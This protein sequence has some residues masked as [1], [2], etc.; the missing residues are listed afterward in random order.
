M[1]LMMTLV[2][3]SSCVHVPGADISGMYHHAQLFSVIGTEP[4]SSYMQMKHSTN[5]IPRPRSWNSS[6]LQRH[7][8]IKVPARSERSPALA[9]PRARALPSSF[10]HRQFWCFPVR[11]STQ[12]RAMSVSGFKFNAP[13]CH[14]T[15]QSSVKSF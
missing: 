5:Q 7:K 6:Y 8:P 14:T 3:R 2:F 15:P 12:A 1:Q 13:N 11:V 9:L 4:R 10:C